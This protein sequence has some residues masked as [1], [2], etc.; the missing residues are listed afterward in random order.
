MVIEYISRYQHNRAQQ[1][2]PTSVQNILKYFI[3]EKEKLFFL[4]AFFSQDVPG[5]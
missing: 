3:V 1:D 4:S 5:G 2:V